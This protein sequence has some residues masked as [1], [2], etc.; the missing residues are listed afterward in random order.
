MEKDLRSI[1][2]EMKDYLL[3]IRDPRNSLTS[4]QRNAELDALKS[5][6]ANN[7]I[8]YSLMDDYES[9]YI[10]FTFNSLYVNDTGIISDVRPKGTFPLS[11]KVDNN[12]SISYEPRYFKELPDL[13]ERDKI[14]NSAYFDL[15]KGS[16][17]QIQGK[18]KY[19]R[20]F[21]KGKE[22]FIIDVVAVKSEKGNCFIATACYNDYDAPE[23]LILR[24]FRDAKLLKN[25]FGK[26][27]VEFYYA[28]SPFLAKIILKSDRLKI[29][30]R[31]YFLNP[32][33]TIL[34]RQK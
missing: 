32:I 14:D 2:K 17:Y 19:G 18:V 16:S 33:V 25:P 30:V 3:Q 8:T 15:Q 6:L 12:I 24:S 28:T 10:N 23:V 26:L 9:G 29:L 11:L 27:F 31:Q 34:R 7:G 21:F 13:Y 22:E 5:S 4:I 1:A 20:Y